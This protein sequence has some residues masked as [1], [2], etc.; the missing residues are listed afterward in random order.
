MKN[1]SSGPSESWWNNDGT[2]W[3]ASIP[4][5]NKTPLSYRLIQD[6]RGKNYHSE[7]FCKRWGFS[8]FGGL[9][10]LTASVQLVNGEVFSDV[11]WSS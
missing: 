11:Q 3:K 9:L 8:S 1:R 5:N 10:G 2:I 7:Q 4:S 6:M